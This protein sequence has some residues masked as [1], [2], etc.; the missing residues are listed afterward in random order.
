MKHSIINSIRKHEG[1]VSKPYIDPLYKETIPK[2]ELEIIEKHWDN[3]NITIGYGTCLQTRTITKK[4][5]LDFVV[6]DLKILEEQLS[7]ALDY[8]YLLPYEVKKVL[9]EMSYQLGVNGLLKFENTLNYIKQKDYEN[10]SIEMLDS[11]WAKQT[12]NR[13]KELSNLMKGGK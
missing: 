2:D 8:F 4:E 5:A 9:F 12:P 1:F 11:L 10:A 6:Y 13:A 7:R 3:L